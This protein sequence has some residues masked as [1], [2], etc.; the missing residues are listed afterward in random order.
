MKMSD[1]TWEVLCCNAN[2]ETGK[3]RSDSHI[4]N[5]AQMTLNLKFN[6]IQEL[7]KE[8]QR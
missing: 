7:K 8:E 3:F 1:K 2:G 6:L 4:N 5:N